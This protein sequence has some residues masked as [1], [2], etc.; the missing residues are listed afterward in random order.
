MKSKLLGIFKNPYV[1]SV[2]S[3][4][5][6]VVLGFLYTV[7]MSRYLGASLKGDV[8]YITS[9]TS[10]TCIIFG[11]G[12]HQAYP[13]FKKK[14]GADVAPIFMR[15]AVEMLAVYLI[16]AVAL[17]LLLRADVSL[18]CILMLT[19]IFVYNRIV[20]YICMVEN[21]N[22]K[23]LVDLIAAFLE[24]VFIV[25]LWLLVKP[26]LLIGAMIYLFKD[27]FLSCV[28]TWR[29]RN[30]LKTHVKSSLSVMF[31]IL[32]FGIFPM[33]VL[34]MST[35]NYRVDVIMLK[36]SV[37]SADVGIY[38]VG[39]MLAER[40]WL[41]PD[42]LKEVMI[43][44]LVKGKGPEEVSFVVRVCNTSCILLVLGIVALGRPFI[45]LFFGAEYAG[46]YP[47]T[48]VIL[49]GVVFMV[50]YKMIAAYNIVHGKQK[51]NFIYLIVSVISNI[52]ANLVLIPLFGCIGA[53]LASIIS[54]SVSAFLFT[55]R[56]IRETGTRM[57]DMLVINRE[58]FV[59][60]RQ[61]LRNNRRT[62]AK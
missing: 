32:K 15:L 47:I 7:L 48:V 45:N 35:L 36:A 39:V 18:G 21:P 60:I 11:C 43:S 10:I 50:Y 37:S 53:A 56:F 41:I 16:L 40:V 28:Y 22:R 42:A 9:V 20:S 13:Y 17:T 25:V 59:R 54:Y 33:L 19:P 26:T 24:V 49:V 6:L 30:A 8:A 62:A 51:E 34:L 29:M 27:I 31:E 55:H 44:N 61:K 58:D 23:N 46:A 57:S 4:I 14:T 12:V 5:T 52:A 1:F 3:K 38:S 2:I